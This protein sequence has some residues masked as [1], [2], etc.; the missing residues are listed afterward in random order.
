MQVQ[1]FTLLTV[2]ICF[3]QH[4]TEPTAKESDCFGEILKGNCSETNTRAFVK[5]VNAGVK[6]HD[7]Y[8]GN[9]SCT[10]SFS[11]PR[12]CCVQEPDDCHGEYI[13]VTTDPYSYHK[14]CIGKNKCSARQ[15][16]RM[17]TLYL[18]SCNQSLYPLQTTYMDVE[19]Y[20]IDVD[21][22]TPLNNGN[23]QNDGQG[24]TLYLWSG[25]S[26]TYSELTV[27][28][29]TCSVETDCD[30]EISVLSMDFRFA[31]DNVNI[32]CIEDNMLSI[33]DGSNTNYFNCSSNNNFE[34]TTLYT[35]SSN[36][37]TV[38]YTGTTAGGYLWLGFQTS[39]NGNLTINC[40]SP[41]QIHTCETSTTEEPTTTEQQTTTDEIT[42]TSLQSTTDETTTG[43]LTS[44]ADQT[45][46]T[47]NSSTTTDK[48]TNGK[49][50]SPSSGNNTGM[51]AG[52]VVAI[53]ILIIIA[54][55]I[56]VY[57]R[58]RKKQALTGKNPEKQPHASENSVKKS[59]G[60][61]V[62][63]SEETQ[64]GSSTVLSNENEVNRENNM[65]NNE[66]LPIELTGPG[67][68]LTQIP[69]PPIT[70]KL[71]QDQSEYNEKIKKKKKK[72]KRNKV[73][74]NGSEIQGNGVLQG[75]G[76]DIK[77]IDENGEHSRKRKKKKKKTKRQENSAELNEQEYFE[78][79]PELKEK[80]KKKKKRKKK[81]REDSNQE[82]ENAITTLTIEKENDPE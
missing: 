54:I 40:Q 79:T 34:I 24:S 47:D 61:N 67:T 17:D 37:I 45:F 15:A 78:E 8:T 9:D 38:Q 16:T 80:K 1:I 64:G 41:G 53:I 77:N 62:I 55:V 74:D 3:A 29:R 20:C 49:S 71:I 65:V 36:Y 46:T 7:R 50:E 27:A 73:D 30:G 21:T 81:Q 22:I 48:V 63:V 66:H 52:I 2:K 57:L 25:D 35:S 43:S 82:E 75:S 59:N 58:H 31:P 76:A 18:T 4:I 72:K 69:L 28:T 5:Q 6:Y 60:E 12:E 70:A 56:G 33:T 10:P 11:A 68:S 13:A 39:T 19:F 32:T 51:I 14:D 42:T 26:S 44:T 23:K